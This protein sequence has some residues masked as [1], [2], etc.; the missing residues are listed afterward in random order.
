MGNQILGKRPSLLI[1]DDEL[2]NFDVL[3]T[4]L[5]REGYDLR[6]A[7]NGKTAL[8]FLENSPPDAVL[9]DVM[10]PEMDGIE[11]CRRIKSSP[12]WNHL[13]VIMVTALTAKED[14]ARCLD[15]GADDFI[16]KPVN[17]QELR[18]RIRSMLRIKQQHDN[19]QSVM[20]LREDMVNMMVHDL[21][22]PL[23]IILM[24]AFIMK[25]PDRTTEELDKN[26]DRIE[27]AG[28]Q[29]QSQIDSLLLMA[30]LES[31][32]MT[33]NRT[34]IDLQTLC[35]EAVDEFEGIASQ[36][37][38]TLKAQLPP[39]GSLVTVDANIFR[40]IIDNL[41]SN[42]IKFSRLDSEVILEAEYLGSGKAII[43][44]KDSGF[45]VNTAVK[46]SIFEKFEIGTFLENV[47]Q[48]GLGLA[49]CRMAIEAHG[50]RITVE[51]NIP[52]GAI[53]SVYL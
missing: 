41:L 42:A 51:D 29:L 5:M 19:L 49:F 23:A 46:Q 26:I 25:M 32:T 18:A 3:E 9:L 33:L 40:R 16:S 21:R 52:Q 50:G 17:A 39:V 10:M 11:V 37:Q 15:A 1:V 44:V 30:K 7:P 12:L 22:T 20:Q 2:D 43:R 53:F 6:Y 47:P 14:L 48:I 24:A 31:G 13:P 35:M 34:S 38:V 28:Y 27:Q 4:L 45:G 36:R 8:A